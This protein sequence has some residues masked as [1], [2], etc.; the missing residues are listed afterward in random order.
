MTVLDLLPYHCNAFLSLP[1]SSVQQSVPNITLTSS[2]S[3]TSENIND[4]F[5]YM[6][7]LTFT[8]LPFLLFDKW[9]L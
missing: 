7:Y 3:L 4:V 1:F 2:L 8:I 5:Q 9:E 6:L